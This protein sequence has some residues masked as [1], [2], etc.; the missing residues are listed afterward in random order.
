L[1]PD[2]AKILL[3]DDEVQIRRFLRASLSEDEFELIEAADGR[4]GIQQCAT[5]SP[6]VVLLDLGL[7]DMDGLDVA[8]SLREWTEVPIIVLSARGQ[9]NDKIAVLE[10]GADDYVTKPFGTG[11]L[12]ARIRVALRHAEMLKGGTLAPLY[13]HEG[14][15][16]DLTTRR[17]TLNEQEVKLTPIEYKLLVLLIRN[18]GK[19][20]THNQILN[21]VWGPAY[22]DEMHYL[23][24]YMARLRHKLEVDATRPI[25]L[26]TEPGVGYRLKG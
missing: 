17:V 2:P 11:E 18:V 12:I 9:E 16:V 10:A 21:E 20:V 24:V 26:L 6:E 22:V 15:R 4:E 5:Q 8:K 19:V 13:E 25:H 7:P 3:I 14:L 1:K 23:R